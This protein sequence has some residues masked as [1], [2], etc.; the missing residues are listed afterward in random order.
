MNKLEE[1]IA[2][3]YKEVAEQKI[4]RPIKH[5][6]QSGHFNGSVVS[7]RE[8]IKRKGSYGIIAEVKRKSPSKGVI[9][10]DISVEE[11]TKGYIQAGAS[12]LSVLTDQQFFGGSSDDL[13]ITR[14]IN[15][16]P[17][18]RKEFIVDE[19][20]ILESKALGADAILLIA[21]V[22]PQK[23]I[24]LFTD[25]A[26]Q[27]KLEVLLEV[28][29]Q[30][31]LLDH[32]ESDADII[33]VNNRDLKTF[34]VDLQA[35]IELLKLIPKG[36][37]RITESGIDSPA[38]AARLRAAGFDGFLIGETFMRAKQP[39]FAAAEFIKELDQLLNIT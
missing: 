31:E 14:R 4:R 16:C 13:M 2:Y 18:L 3:K 36:K 23:E 8:A 39:E 30:K 24:R 28:H 15:T 17:I 5:L 20:Q 11:I 7:L 10:G 35:S 38:T 26:H 6:E 21:A 22:L 29:S 25:L 33:G 34:A 37:I 12:A 1:I 19:Y 9:N 32:L 27:L